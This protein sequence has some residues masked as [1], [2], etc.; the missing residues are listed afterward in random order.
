MAHSYRRLLHLWD[1]L[2]LTGLSAAEIYRL[3]SKGKFPHPII[4]TTNH[5]GWDEDAVQDWVVQRLERQA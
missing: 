2:R 1:I 5:K 4:S 3:M